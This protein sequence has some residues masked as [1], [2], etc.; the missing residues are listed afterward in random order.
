[1][2]R[3][4]LICV[5]LFA[6]SVAMAQSETSNA[7]QRVAK[8]VKSLGRYEV[9][10][11]LSSGEF[12]AKGYFRVECDIYYMNIGTAEV[13]SDGKVRYEVDNERKEINIDGV[14]LSSRN[15]LDNP[16]RCFDFVGSDYAVKSESS[17]AGRT[18]ICLSAED[19]DIEGVI[20]LIFDE[21]SG[22]P[23]GLE[24]ELYDERVVID[25]VSIVSAK[26]QI[27]RF[28]QSAYKGYEVVDF[29]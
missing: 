14:D 21:K 6:A 20:T 16:T 7:L 22:R 23:I 15:V 24:Y 29:R 25:V 12:S 26:E 2:R 27:K 28:N 19:K 3:I 8:Y 4:L 1:M 5:M 10:F 11:A 9:G 17:S 13:Y 18:K